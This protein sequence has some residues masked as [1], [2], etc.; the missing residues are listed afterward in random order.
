M[1]HLQCKESAVETRHIAV[2]SA[3]FNFQILFINITTQSVDGSLTNFADL[4]SFMSHYI[5][6]QSSNASK[7]D[8]QMMNLLTFLLSFP[9]GMRFVH[10]A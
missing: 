2:Y 3:N 8:D 7:F 4:I 6:H 9:L 1:L 5:I 10:S